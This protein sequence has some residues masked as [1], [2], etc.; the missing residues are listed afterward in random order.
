MTAG[1][2]PQTTFG[3][4]DDAIELAIEVDPAGAVRLTR[5]AAGPAL[6]A[7]DGRRSAASPTGL[8]LVDIVLAGEGRAWS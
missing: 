2:Q 4:S 8:P 7:G 5:L 6:A 1:T 3:W